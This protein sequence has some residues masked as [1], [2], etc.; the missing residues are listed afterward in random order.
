[1][2]KIDCHLHLG[3]VGTQVPVWWMDELYGMYGVEDWASTDGQA[4]VDL[5]D[6][7]EMDAGLVQGGDIRRTTFHPDY[8]KE[9]AGQIYIPNDWTAEQCEL[10]KGRLYGVTC[11]DPFRDLPGGV[12]ELERCVTELDF[13]SMK[14]LPSYLHF[15]PGDRDLDP[16][17]R[18]AQELDVPVH[19]FTGMTPTRN[20]MLEYGDPVLLDSVGR[21]HRDLKVIVFVNYPWIDQCIAL[22]SKHPNFHADMCY[23]AGGDSGQLYDVLCKFRSYGALDRVIFGTDNADKAREVDSVGKVS[24]LYYGLNKVAE[25]RG[26][27]PFSEDELDAILGGTASKLYKIS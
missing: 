17:Y 9:S 21:R 27:E 5:L 4:I 6:A 11:I 25:E 22:V 20:A 8:P 12:I 15:S 16:L 19:F 24:D 18:K 7:N 10:H 23:F 26:G 13:R 14:L 3:M 1:M 2:I